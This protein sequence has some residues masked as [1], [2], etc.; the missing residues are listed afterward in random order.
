[1]MREMKSG[2]LSQVGA[3]ASASGAVPHVF[4]NIRGLLNEELVQSV[5]GVFQ[6]K[7]SGIEAGDWYID[8]KNGGGKP[9]FKLVFY[10]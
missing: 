1:M 7:L 2:Q 4:D 5:N 6:F 3:S 10:I 8:L 9:A